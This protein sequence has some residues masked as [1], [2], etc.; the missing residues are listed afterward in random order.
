MLQKIFIF[1]VCF[2]S[3]IQFQLAFGDDDPVVQQAVVPG[4]NWVKAEQKPENCRTL[5]AKS[6]ESREL[7]K[8]GL[9]YDSLLKRLDKLAE[10]NESPLITE[11]ERYFDLMGKLDE[12][13]K[14]YRKQLVK[15]QRF[16]EHKQV[17]SED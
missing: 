16:L 6:P 11:T 4:G 5:A 3:G 7:K 9:Q 14:E 1:S 10:E 17:C 15:E 13:R 2:L 12:L 8:L